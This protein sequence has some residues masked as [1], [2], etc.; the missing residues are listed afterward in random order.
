M[1]SPDTQVAALTALLAAVT[2]GEPRTKETAAGVIRIEADLPADLRD[3]TRTA[4][5]SALTM[6]D[7]YGHDRSTDRDVVWAE[8]DRAETTPE[9]S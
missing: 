3:S 1:C 7:R 4:I 9:A 5:L 2:G 6:A 8:L